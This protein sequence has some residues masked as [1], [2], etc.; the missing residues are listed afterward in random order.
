M[1]ESDMVT[2]VTNG[3]LIVLVA[4]LIPCLYR[5]VIGPS[6][7]DRLQA[8]DTMNVLLIGIIVLLALVKSTPILVDIGLALAAFSFV[9]TLAIARYLCE[10]RMF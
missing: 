3:G 4:L 6:P 2:L 1:I 7:A 5:V 8:L 10:G 9:S